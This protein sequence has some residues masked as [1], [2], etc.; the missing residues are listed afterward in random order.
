MNRRKTLTEPGALRM[1]ADA[2]A[3]AVVFGAVIAFLAVPL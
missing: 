1:L 3:L 2:I